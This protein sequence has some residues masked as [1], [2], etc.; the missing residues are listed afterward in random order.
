M[1][2][3]LF[4]VLFSMVLVVSLL[5]LNANAQE[6]VSFTQSIT[7]EKPSAEVLKSDDF[8]TII[9]FTI[10]GMEVKEIIENTEKFQSLRFPDY[11]TTLEI[12]KPYVKWGQVLQ[13][14]NYP[15]STRG[16]VVSDKV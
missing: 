1:Y 9:K 5:P 6:W 12:G 15:P 13:Y 8:E 3:K 11:Y 4:I 16:I 10:P 14:Y 7:S 2:Y